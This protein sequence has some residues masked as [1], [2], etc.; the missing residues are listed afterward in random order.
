MSEPRVG[1]VSREPCCCCCLI[2]T[3]G[4]EEAEGRIEAA[5]EEVMVAAT[6]WDGVEVRLP[7]IS[8]ER[9]GLCRN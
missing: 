2:D 3:R 8:K 7:A 5:P 1:V 6:A 4:V 9:F